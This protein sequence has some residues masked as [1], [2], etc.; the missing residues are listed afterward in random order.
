MEFNDFSQMKKDILA[1]EKLEI[2]ETPSLDAISEIGQEKIESLKMS[3]S[4]INTLIISRE[5]MSKQF[6]EDGELL[7]S[8]INKFILENDRIPLA[9]QR[10][11]MREKNDL[12][13]KK[14]TIVESQLKER[15]DCWKDIANLKKER[16]I[17]ERE[18]QEK[19]S[20]MN[21]LGGFLEEN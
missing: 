12:R 8:E 17:Y 5:Q 20:R 4:E 7:K 21:I 19:E 2:G 13:G 9:D 1:P 10:E 18:L 16:R 3:I 11:I 15:I 6:F 14:V